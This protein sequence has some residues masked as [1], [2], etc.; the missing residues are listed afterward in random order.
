A[1]TPGLMARSIP[2]YARGDAVVIV[3]GWSAISEIVLGI[4]LGVNFL[5]TGLGYIFV[6]RALKPAA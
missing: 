6:S 2:G 1:T 4:L 3:A 5:S